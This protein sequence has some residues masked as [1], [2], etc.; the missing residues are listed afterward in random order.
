[1][2]SRNDIVLGSEELTVLHG[3][4]DA[5]WDEIASEY[6]MSATCVEVGR[7][8]LANAVLTA[9]QCGA[10]TSLMIKAAALRRMAMWRHE[11]RYAL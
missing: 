10:C 1:M 11:S 9:Y 3:A 2:R 8:R 7:L 6:D 5:I 4:F